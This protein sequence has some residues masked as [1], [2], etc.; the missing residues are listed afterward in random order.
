MLPLLYIHLTNAFDIEYLVNT[1]SHIKY[2][3]NSNSMLISIQKKRIFNYIEPLTT[4]KRSI[5]HEGE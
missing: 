2:I 5:K 1:L 3:T 4:R